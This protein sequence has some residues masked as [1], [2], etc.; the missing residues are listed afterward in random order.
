MAEI[1][2]GLDEIQCKSRISSWKDVIHRRHTQPPALKV[3]EETVVE[4]DV[5]DYMQGVEGH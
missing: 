1:A 2:N 4:Q 3:I 5:R